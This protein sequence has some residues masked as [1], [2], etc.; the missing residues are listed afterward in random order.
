MT[1]TSP[2]PIVRPPASTR[3]RLAVA[4]LGLLGVA[5]AIVVSAVVLVAVIDLR[6]M[7]ERY[8]TRTLERR[9]TIGTL[10]IA[11]GNP[12]RVEVGDV[13]VANATW[14][15]RPDMIRIE[16]LTATVDVIPLLRGVLRF[17]TLEVRKPEIVLERDANGIGNWRFGDAAARPPASSA[18]APSRRAGF[19]TLIDF[20]LHDGFVSYRTTNGNVL[21]GDL[22]DVSI[23][24]AG[25]DQPVSVTL[26]GAYN[27]TP[28]RVTA[29]TQ[30]FQA[31]RDESLPFGLAFSTATPTAT[32]EFKGTMMNPL[33]FDGVRGPLRIDAR[34]LGD[35]LNIFGADVGADVPLR[36]AGALTRNGDHWQLTEATGTL[37]S[38]AFE[39]GLTLAEGG[40]GEPDDI[41]IA[42]TFAVLHLDPLLAGAAKGKPG[43]GPSNADYGALS[44]DLEQKRGTN[45]DATLR[46][47][48]LEYRAMRFADVG[49]EARL[50]SGEIAIR[51]LT[52]AVAGGT[53]D[54]SGSARSAK[55]GSRVVVNASVSKADAAEIARML[56][57]EAGQIA[58]RITTRA[59]LTMSGATVGQA[60][61]TGRGH[62]VLAM[63]DGDIARA[64]LERVSTD[65]R[66]LWRRNER[67]AR[68]SCLLGVIELR[69]GRGTIAQLA[70][71]TPAGILI[72]GGQVDFAAQRL[73]MTIKSVASSTSAFALDIPLRVSGDFARLS[74][75]PATSAGPAEAP[76]RRGPPNEMPPDLRQLAEANPCPR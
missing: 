75:A 7:L 45:F 26:E 33:D 66:S 17:E 30:S 65:L 56:G 31:L 4:L 19:P 35:F 48:Q 28:T 71:Q 14:G 41:A 43:K 24:A 29:E 72:G 57:V 1:P 10:H 60:L 62:A 70:L 21:R 37:A 22:R 42:A 11:W 59:T 74:V 46:A 69:D 73:D 51:R 38:D 52:F 18:P 44:L 36:L 40:R 64:Q 20:R 16:T 8:A 3:K 50:A 39:G 54:A 25:D 6:P 53:V 63:K 23:R 76:T 67:S 32:V 2:S 47:A 13:R 55:P 12:L 15:S 5:V 58:G 68:I 27:G 9:L 61:R 49:A 34:V